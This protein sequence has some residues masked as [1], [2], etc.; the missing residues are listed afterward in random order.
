MHIGYKIPDQLEQS[1]LQVWLAFIE[2]Q[3]NDVLALIIDIKK[4]VYNTFF[5]K[6]SYM[7]IL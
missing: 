3:A 5:M 4:R 6:T 2:T 7:I 1:L